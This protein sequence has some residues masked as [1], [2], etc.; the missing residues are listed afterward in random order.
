VNAV[1]TADNE[2]ERRRRARRNAVLLGLVAI[3]VY[4]LFIA[5]TVFGK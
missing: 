4:V 3:G 2:T 5:M 1:N